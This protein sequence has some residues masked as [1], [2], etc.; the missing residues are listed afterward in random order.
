MGLIA[1]LVG[2][3]TTVHIPRG[4]WCCLLLCG[5][6]SVVDILLY[7]IRNAVS[8][9][10]VVGLV[11]F[12]VLKATA[13]TAIYQCTRRY[14]VAFICAIALIVLFVICSIVNFVATILYDRGIS[15]TLFTIF[16]ETD[17]RE[18][19]GFIPG[20][21][22]NLVSMVVSTVVLF[23][24][25]GIVVLYVLVRILQDKLFNFGV[26]LL[27]CCGVVYIVVVF[28]SAGWGKSNH[29]LLLR[30]VRYAVAAY[31]DCQDLK[32]ADQLR[33][34]L[35]CPESAVTTEDSLDIVMVIGESSARLHNS[36]YGYPL[37]T[38]PAMSTIADSLFLFSDA[39][40]SSSSTAGNM[41][42]IL[43]FMPDSILGKWYEY[44]SVIQVFKQLGFRTYWLS[45]QERTGRI[46]NA[47]TV[48]AA[49]ADFACY[50]GAQSSEDYIL[51]AYDEALMPHVDT[52]MR[53][54]GSKHLIMLHLIGSHSDYKDRFP[55]TRAKI[56]PEDEMKMRPRPWLNEAKAAV[57]AAYDNSIIYTDS[58]LYQMSR[59]IAASPRPGLLIYFSDHGEHIYDNRDHVGRDCNTVTVPMFI[60]ANN[61]FRIQNHE[62]IE[63]LSAAVDKPV[64]TANI[65]H[66]LL[67]LSNSSYALYEPKFDFLSNQ[68]VPRVR[69]VDE[70]PW[71]QDVEKLKKSSGNR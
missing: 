62:L 43:T 10:F 18:I 30:T 9:W 7:D 67:T 59:R 60:Y 11:C 70:E 12:A 32:S 20:L 66:S 13:L 68:Y 19:V 52:A 14:R 58:L 49:D 8:G 1:K 45:N 36:L 61:A 6:M 48:I 28:M 31:M 38:N 37:N 33:R 35:Y 71:G 3:L 17:Q 46:H 2:K 39:I 44:P 22:A 55:R 29:I 57:C 27:S 53:D 15:G 69:Y 65:I 64:T 47:S 21:I 63:R 42:R 34:P 23:S 56:T 50:V 51:I 4:M 5:L 25:C 16:I 24:V 26:S 54:V 41:P 40:G